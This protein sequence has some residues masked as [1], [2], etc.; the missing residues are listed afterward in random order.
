MNCTIPL[1][2]PTPNV[3]SLTPSPP[4]RAVLSPTLKTVIASNC[5]LRLGIDDIVDISYAHFAVILG[6]FRFRAGIRKHYEIRRYSPDVII[7]A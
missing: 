4:R 2:H 6:I 1:E 7:D 5:G 3:T